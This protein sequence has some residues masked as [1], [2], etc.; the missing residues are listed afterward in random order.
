MHRFIRPALATLIF[1]S[2]T[3]GVMAQDS[4]TKIEEGQLAVSQCYSRCTGQHMD[5]LLGSQASGEGANSDFDNCLLEQSLHHSLDVC[6]TGCKDFESVFGT[7]T[8]NARTHVTAILD[9][10][11]RYLEP[12]GLWAP[13]SGLLPY[14]SPEFDQA[15]LTFLRDNSEY[16]WFWE[17]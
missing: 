11:S 4:L 10:L 9:D 17:Y 5:T 13:G 6:M 14:G 8:S 1:A 7:T 12:S 15:C 3:Q 16:Y 2:L